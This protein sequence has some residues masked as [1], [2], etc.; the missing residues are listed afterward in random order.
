MSL[1]E[2][3]R[4]S[5]SAE[6]LGR[7]PRWPPERVQAIQRLRL[8][9]LVAH[10][11][12][13][14]PFY[15][16]KLRDIDPRAFELADLP[17]T[18]K[19]ELRERFDDSVT[20]PALRRDDVERFLKDEHNLGQWHL[21]RYALSRTSGSQGPPLLLAQDRRAIELL[22]ALM[23][24]RGTTARPGPWE[25][26]KRLA[27]PR[28]I[29]IVASRRGFYPSGAALEFMQSI[30]GPFVRV[31]RY[32]ALQPDLIPRLNRFQPHVL[33]AYASVLEALIDDADRPAFRELVQVSNSSERLTPSARRRVQEAFAVPII[34]HYG[35]GECLHLSDGCPA[36]GIHVNSDWAILEV[37]D[38]HNRPVPNGQLGAKVLVTNLANQ[39]QPFLRYEVGDQLA[40]TD[41]PCECGSR[42]PRIERIEGRAADVFWVTDGGQE[43]FVSGVVFHAAVDALRVAREWQ[44]VQVERNRVHLRIELLPG[45]EMSFERVERLLWEALWRE[46][47]P[48][49]VVV[50]VEVVDSIRPDPWTGKMR[51]MTAL[52]PSGD[53]AR[54]ASAV[55]AA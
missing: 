40:L 36:G 47:L 52:A 4:Y 18:R 16:E 26:L 3:L 22:L 21:G 33:V 15:A 10:A 23:S 30:V 25:G 11:Q 24:A 6:Q 39:G 14:S 17:T 41:E 46:G 29:A 19:E 53:A 28:R 38:E 12:A 7:V 37:V 5:R 9:R 32:S 1:I 20:D 51:R 54:G 35:M 42:L 2:V 43:R 31:Q 55:S 8:Q 49:S 45:C 50:R 44:A 27:A 48:G 34:D 13:H